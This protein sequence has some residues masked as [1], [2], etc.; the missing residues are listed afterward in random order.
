MT[1]VV[2]NTT[3]KA[4]IVFSYCDCEELANY[5]YKHL[6]AKLKWPVWMDKHDAHSGSFSSSMAEA[7]EKSA[8]IICFLTPE[9]Q[10]TSGCERELTYAA[11]LRK[12]LIPIIVGESNIF[13]NPGGD[14]DDADDESWYPTDWLGLVVADLNVIYFEGVTE[15][16]IN[17]KCDDLMKRIENIL[18]NPVE[19]K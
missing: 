18:K 11:N 2:K 7:I 5:V 6:K 19:K 17:E 14:N 16:N 13:D 8:A 4:P 15:N 12:P 9:Y 1:T 3:E 10:A